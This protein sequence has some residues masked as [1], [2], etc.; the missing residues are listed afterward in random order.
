MPDG[1]VGHQAESLGGHR[2]Y[3]GA[4]CVYLV[5]LR[6]PSSQRGRVCEPCQP[7]GKDTMA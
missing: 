3:I 6:F 2:G 4:V 1:N 5:G 7:M